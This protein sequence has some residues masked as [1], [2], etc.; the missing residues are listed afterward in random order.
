[1]NRTKK[2]SIGKIIKPNRLILVGLIFL[3]LSHTQ[4][5]IFISPGYNLNF[6]SDDG[7][8]G[9]LAPGVGFQLGFTFAVPLNRIQGNYLFVEFSP[10]N[11]SY[12]Q[13]FPDQSIRSVLYAESLNLGYGHRLS[14]LVSL[15]GGAQVIFPY[16]FKINSF[17][18][19]DYI[20]RNHF[21]ALNAAVKIYF[22][23]NSCIRVR[24]QHGFGH[25][26]KAEKI[27]DF[28]DI[29]EIVTGQSRAIS[30]EVQFR[31]F[32]IFKNVD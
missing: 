28:G 25:I 20:A 24:Y 14:D 8:M 1:M 22:S 11:L 16:N 9:K 7:S 12:I 19:D 21:F 31:V 4:A 5:Q 15:E 26:F 2:L 10:Q 30:L 32:K 27:G 29:E 3:S 6:L 17:R 23:G 18:V 13:V